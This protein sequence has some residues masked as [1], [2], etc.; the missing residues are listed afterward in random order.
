MLSKRWISELTQPSLSTVPSE[1]ITQPPAQDASTDF[2]FEDM[3]LIFATEADKDI[4]TMRRA[5]NQLGQD[6]HIEPGHFELFRSRGHKIRGSA[7]FVE[8][9]SIVKIAQHIEEIARRTVQGT[10]PPEISVRALEYAISA[11]ETTFQDAVATGEENAALLAILEEEL[12][13]LA[14]DEEVE[15][16]IA[17]PTRLF[18]PEEIDN[19]PIL[20]DKSLSTQPTSSYMRIDARRFAD[21]LNH[22]EQ[23]GELRTPLVSALE[24]VKSAL[25]ELHSAQNQLTQLKSKAFYSLYNP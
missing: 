1:L 19:I 24:Q 25:Q 9:H 11:L 16:P 18:Q 15:E 8:F 4:N 5:L 6:V 3:L 14:I 22:A 17:T 23:L 21:L 12:K 20:S 10:I 13:S 7:G 2:S